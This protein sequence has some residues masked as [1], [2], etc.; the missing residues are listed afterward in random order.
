[1]SFVVK[2]SERALIDLAKLKRSEPV[3]YKKAIALIR[4][5]EQHPTT[6]TGHPKPLGGNRAGR[7]SRHISHNHR[8]VYRI[9]EEI[10]TVLVL[11]AYGHYDDK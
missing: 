8:L 2:A 3:S 9:Q 4:E 5:L 1:M 7:W 6:G 11:T 10:V